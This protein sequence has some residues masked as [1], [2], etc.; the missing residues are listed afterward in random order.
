MRKI[1]I[2]LVLGFMTVFGIWAQ[3]AKVQATEGTIDLPTYIRDT[4]EA[5]PIF[6]RDWSYQ[7]ARR[8]VYPY[9]LD[10]NMTREKKTVT[11]KALYLEN[12]YIKLCVLPEIG[13]RLYY[14][15]DK[16]N[17]YDIIY[18]NHVIKPGNV[19]MLG[20]WISGGVE[21]N[22]FH[23][24]RNTTNMPVDYKIV[25]N[26]DGSQTIW[27]GETELR[28]RMQWAIGITLYPGKS[29]MEITGRLINS[30][31]NN[32]S[33]LYW[34]N[35]ATHVDENYQ[36]IFP[37][38]VEFGMFHCKNSFCHWPVTQEPY[39]GIEEYSNGIDAS[40]WKNHF[41]SNSIF[42]YDQ[43]EDF[44]AGYDYG[45]K[46][47][48]MITANHHI[49]KGGK[50]WLWGPNS[51]WDSKILTDNS[52]HYCE[53]MVGAY[54]DN[55]PDYNWSNPYEV[56]QFTHYLYG[57]RDIAGV[58]TG[59]RRAALN[60]ELEQNGKVLMGANVTE[61]MKNVT[62]VLSARGKN[63]FNETLDMAPDKPFVKRLDVGKNIAET[64]LTMTLIDVQGKQLLA[65]TPIVNRGAEKPLPEIVDEPLLPQQ[66]ENTEECYL[67][68]LRNLQFHNPFI[69]P[70][71]YFEEVLR[72]DP[73]DTRANT[74]MGV[75]WR[76][77][78]D[79]PKAA[80]YLRRAIKRQTKDYTRPKDGEAMY[81]L[82]LILKAEGHF[83][84]A[85]DTLYRAVW[86]YEYNSAANYQLAQLYVSA[87]DYE[88]ALE[89]LNEA[90]IY[91]GN[92]FNALNLKA[93][94]LRHQGK[95]QEAL[96]CIERTLETDPINAYATH[97]K[98][99][100]DGGKAFIALMRDIPESYLELAI[101]Y[102]HNGFLKEAVEILKDIDT[103]VVY[104]TIRMYLAFWADKTGDKNA[105]KKYYESALS[106]PTD[107]CNMFRLETVAVL[108]KAKEYVPN[109]DKI[110]YYLGNLFY[111]KQPDTAMANWQQCVAINPN[112]AM[113][114][115]NLGW[116][117]CLH[118]GDL[119]QSAGCYRKAIELLP[120][121]PLFLEEI[122]QV[123]E[124]KGED[125]QV[126]YDLL[127]S[128]HQTA[129]K[130]YYPLA[131]EVITGTFVGDYDYVLDLLKNCYFPTREGV[132]NFHDI[133]VDA[134]MMAAQEKTAKGQYTEA[135]ALYE[136]C[137]E[138]PVNH[139]VFLVDT[140]VPRDAQT[141]YFIGETYEKAG[142]R[143]KA[144]LNYKK[145]AAVN[146][147]TTDYRY[148]QALALQKLKKK[149]EA[150]NIFENLEET[151]RSGIVENVINFYGAEGTTGS[152]VE[153]VNTRAY[154]TL[155]LGQLGLS[156]KSDA[157]RSFA[158]SVELKRDNLWANFMEKQSK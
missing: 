133:Y 154:Y 90:L 156:K 77:R 2:V 7:R 122:D 29:Y 109:N 11:Y 115:R 6:E 73:N 134:L 36:I 146:A 150:Q 24:H 126:R 95:K 140:R 136:K 118:T 151:G 157:L 92:N 88:S 129:L 112:C 19:G 94:I 67:V 9:V 20:A 91:N 23:H 119:K 40:W 72:R 120:E 123:Y 3:E 12:E 17:N 84:A 27:V 71:D 80:A 16:T 32:N 86:N 139:Q 49:V 101:A 47:G 18:Y 158:K 106:L 137:F 138:Y 114:W 124:L 141:Y 1:A 113:A 111:D 33:M 63:I 125:V 34:S 65:Y 51:E 4:P 66:I 82:G 75:W 62:V 50:F 53:L 100:L 117:H 54:S 103:R 22:A 44:L 59:N 31:A 28:H 69:N 128:H 58:K 96:N 70:V 14:A 79:N 13:G 83:E 149:K 68:G 143:S 87:G 52:G 99:L 64:E 26:P 57:V 142:N 107:Y 148:W 144:A 78:G 102:W 46:A 97:E 30:T 15:I 45:R 132:A 130:R 145:S 43:K 8:S 105:A 131:A 60:L 127:K 152:T 55:Q 110:Y 48:T 108:E 38:S 39:N 21:W 89:R 41:M 5:V 56:K 10:D 135:V 35:I 61:K 37:Q 116:G 85:M 76:Q 42:I 93:A 121:E 98:E 104:P 25:E 155:G 74:Q 81:N 147:K 153:S